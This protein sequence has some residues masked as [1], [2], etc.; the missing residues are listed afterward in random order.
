MIPDPCDLPFEEY[1]AWIKAHTTIEM[2]DLSVTEIDNT[3]AQVLGH[4]YATRFTAL[5]VRQAGNVLWVAMH[6]PLNIETIGNL[7]ASSDCYIEPLLAR[8]ED[9]RYYINQT[10]G[11]D[12]VHSI[13]SQFV[14]EERLRPDTDPALLAELNAAPAVRL[15]DT[16]IDSGVLNSA[17]DLHIEPYGRRLRARYRADGELLTHSTVDISLLPNVISRL[18]VMGGMDIAEKRMPQDGH[19]A[20]SV[21]GQKVDFRL[22]TI[23]TVH[24]E[25]AVIRL[26][27]GGDARIKKND[28]GF[29]PEDLEKLTRLFHQPYGAIIITGPTGSGKSTTLSAFLEELNNAGRNIITVEDPVENP[30]L[31]VSH[32]NASHSGG[33]GFADALKHI[34]RQDP[35]VIMVGEMRDEETA[36]IAVQAALTGHVVLSTLHTNDAAGVIERLTDMGVEHY[37]AA[38]ALN[39]IISQRLVRR[40][41]T[42]CS[43]PALLSREQAIILELAPDTPVFAGAGCGRCHFSGYRGRFAVYE[44]VLMNEALRRHMSDSPALFAA[45]LRKERGLRRNALQALLSGQTSAEEVIKALH[46]DG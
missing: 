7:A 29:L 26:L 23:P 8:E 5:P 41:C 40:V 1:A 35:D 17:S 24:G 38:A 36:R 33:L 45:T 3:A 19:F 11:A 10:Y 20:M 43:A 32:I 34:L 21:Q 37:L 15:I 42:D 12:A 44:Y 14:V 22:S 39:G 16:L 9:I 4:E 2:I 31:G 25:K 46:R 6:D 13:A 27:Y 28:L 18:K 30:L